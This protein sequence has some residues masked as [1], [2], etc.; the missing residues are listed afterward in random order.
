VYCHEQNVSR[1]IDICRQS[2][3]FDS[4]A[5]ICSCLLAMSQDPDIALVRIKNRFNPAL[6]SVESAGYRNLAVNLRVDTPEARAL[7]IETHICE[8]QLLL[9]SMAAIKVMCPGFAPILQLPCGLRDGCQ[10]F[11]A[12][13]QISL[14]V[15]TNDCNCYIASSRFALANLNLYCL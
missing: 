8:V 3:Y 13:M 7:G 11:I 14:Y 12:Q 15:C 2:I 6:Q 9:I 10:M 5:D 4:I 1:L